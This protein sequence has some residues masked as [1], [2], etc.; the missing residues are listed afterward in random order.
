MDEEF[1]PKVGR[2]QWGEFAVADKASVPSPLKGSV[3]LELE[4]K[5]AASALETLSTMSLASSSNHE[6]DEEMESDS[7]DNQTA[8]ANS[9]QESIIA[10]V[11]KQKEAFFKSQQRGEPTLTN[12]QKRAIALEL[13]ESSP[14]VF[15]S[16]YGSY[17]E[18]AHFQ[19]FLQLEGTYEVKFYLEKIEK[20]KKK[21]KQV[22]NRRYH[23]MKALIEKGG[24]F[25]MPEMK[26]RNP[27]LFE[28]LVGK[29]MS[30][31]E[32][33]AMDQRPNLCSLSTVLME[34]ID[35]DGGSSQRRRDQEAE[36]LVW[37]G[38]SSEDE[39]ESEPPNEEE[40][41]M[42]EEE[43][44]SSKYLNNNAV[45]HCY[46]FINFDNRY[47]QQLHGRTR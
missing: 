36:E 2:S 7:T 40:K 44:R 32:K 17:L 23:A 27:M 8:Y 6:D 30:K 35:R 42:M 47:V 37:E 9:L 26:E 15:L 5:N 28:R 34:H 25:S 16:R 11:V 29:Y 39:D 24:Y 20:D 46:I 3:L 41:K 13:L 33:E 12:Q 21:G 14:S 22:R 19:Y 45:F 4:P 31:E 38:E 43:F 10:H 18:E 1:D